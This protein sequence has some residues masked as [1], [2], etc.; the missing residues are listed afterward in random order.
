MATQVPGVGQGSPDAE[1]ILPCFGRAPFPA[2][3]LRTSPL[4]TG[5]D[6]CPSGLFLPR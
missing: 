4:E 1:V 5:S 6:S 2:T 3:L